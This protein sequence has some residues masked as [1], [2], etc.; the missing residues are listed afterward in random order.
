METEK[1]YFKVGLFFL[2]ALA[3]FLYYVTAF[4]RDGGSQD[5]KRY[6][7]YFDRSVAGLARGAP[8]KLKGIMVGVV[9]N[10]RFVSADNDRIL[11]TADIA[12][13]APVRS[14][15]VASVAFQGITGAAYLALE[16]SVPAAQSQ[17]LAVQ[18]GEDYP[19]IAARTSDMQTLMSEAP[20]TLARV[21]ATVTQAQKLLS[22]KNVETAQAL[23]P[24][25]HDALTEAAAAF[26]EIKML[27]REIREDPSI[28]LHG[29][30]YQ[31][32]QVP[33]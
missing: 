20:A 29:P 12:D 13:T 19:V 18:K 4:S 1:H 24:E 32:Y 3:A 14:D 30:K 33:K 26:R 9:S 31:G 17:P 10:I 22:D 25:A 11:V 16:N 5:L 27:A 23:L 15:T 21:N 7:V 8:V 6:A 28:I 2:A